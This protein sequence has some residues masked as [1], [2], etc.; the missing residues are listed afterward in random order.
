V[1]QANVTGARE[2]SLAQVAPVFSA[3][4]AINRPTMRKARHQM[5]RGGAY[6]DIFKPSSFSIP[7]ALPKR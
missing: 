5:T 1:I 3:R 6:S 4:V 7:Y 2:A